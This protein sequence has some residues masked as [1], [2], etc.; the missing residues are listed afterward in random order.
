MVKFV[1]GAGFQNWRGVGFLAAGSTSRSD[2]KIVPAST[3]ADQFFSI[4][5][6]G[7]GEVSGALVFA[8]SEVVSPD[9]VS[10]SNKDEG[11]SPAT[12]NRVDELISILAVNEKG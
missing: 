12:I 10:T 4:H 2:Q 3:R 8:K 11:V 9:S 5:T 7:T 6:I 1:I